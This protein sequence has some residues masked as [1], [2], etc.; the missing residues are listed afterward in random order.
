MK[1][2]RSHNHQ[3]GT[4]RNLRAGRTADIP[5]TISRFCFAM[6]GSIGERGGGA[7]EAG[8]ESMLGV[9]L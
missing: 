6:A 1:R 3:A 4:A 7:N 5:A 9:D 2:K 8:I